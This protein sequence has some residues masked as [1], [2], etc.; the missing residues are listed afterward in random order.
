LFKPLNNDWSGNVSNLFS[1]NGWSLDNGSILKTIMHSGIKEQIALATDP[2]IIEQ[3]QDKIF[4][5][6]FARLLLVG[7]FVF[8][9]VLV[10]AAYQKRRREGRATL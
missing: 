7:L 2:L 10:Y 9:S 6:N 8:I 4:Y 3:L 1:G 5:L